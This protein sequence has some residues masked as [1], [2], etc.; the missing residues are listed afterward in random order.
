MADSTKEIAVK[1]PKP[2]GTGT[3]ATNKQETPKKSPAAEVASSAP[4]T[5]AKPRFGFFNT[6]VGRKSSAAPATTQAGATGAVAAPPQRQRSSMGKFFFGMS[7]YMILALAAQFV[8]SFIFARLPASYSTQALFQIPLL[9]PVTAYLL[10]WMVVLIAILYA[11]YKF[12]II[13]R[14]LGQ[15][16]QKVASVRADPKAAPRTTTAKITREPVEGPNDDAYARVKARIRA[17]RR[18]GRHS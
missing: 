16:R 5:E 17:E 4:A 10:V 6:L 15:P 18:K 9:G 14:N 2:K 7:L 12:N 13:P 11:L 3:A 8:L 1:R